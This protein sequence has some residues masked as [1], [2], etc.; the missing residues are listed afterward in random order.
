MALRPLV[1][2]EREVYAA[3][4][5]VARMENKEIHRAPIWDCVD[6][7]DAT[8]LHGTVDGIVGGY[9]CQ[10]FS[11]AGR[12]EGERDPRHLW[13]HFERIIKECEPQ[14]C[15]FENV[16]NHL[17]LGFRGVAESLRRLG[18]NVETTLVTAEEVGAP[19]KRE[20]LFILANRYSERLSIER[21]EKSYSFWNI[22]DGCS[23]KAMAN[24]SGEQLRNKSGW[25]CWEGRCGAPLITANCTELADTNSENGW[26]EQQPGESSEN[27]WPGP[28]RVGEVFPPGRDPNDPKWSEWPWPSVESEIRERFDGHPYWVDELRL[29]GGGVVPLQAAYAYHVLKTGGGIL[30]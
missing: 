22:T 28:E 23:G 15:F 12:K 30:G 9:P 6:T 7:F 21:G 25:G 11:I 17:R 27:R 2:V 5:L 20:R 10:P 14:W 4:N 29:N 18:Y 16:A 26:S 1:Y 19:H 3:A 13:P 8:P 24:S